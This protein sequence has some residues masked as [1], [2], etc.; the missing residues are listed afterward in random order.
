MKNSTWLA[1]LLVLLFWPACSVQAQT[2]LVVQEGVTV[3][4]S[5]SGHVNIGLAKAAGSG[6]T[7]EL[8]SPDWKSPGMNPLQV[9]VR[10][11]VPTSVRQV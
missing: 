10:P 1:C 11:S 5:L 2:Q 4:R 9:K 8:R 3:S 7:V 6:V